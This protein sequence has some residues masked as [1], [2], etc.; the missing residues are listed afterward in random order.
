MLS[1]YFL[2]LYLSV[3]MHFYHSVTTRADE[4]FK[5]T[6]IV[7]KIKLH[8]QYPK[9]T[10]QT[11]SD[12]YFIIIYTICTPDGHVGYQLTFALKSLPHQPPQ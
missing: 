7:M 2:A 8:E 11:F 4:V 3:C 9:L 1:D 10:S 5:H 12:Y 6:F